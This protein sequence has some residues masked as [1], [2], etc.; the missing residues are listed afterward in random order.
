MKKLELYVVKDGKE[1]RCGYT[2]GSC[3]AA[4]TKA[5][6]LLLDGRLDSDAVVI[7][8]PKGIEIEIDVETAET[9]GDYAEVSVKKDSGDD[10][11]ITDGIEIFSKVRKREDGKISFTGG[12]GVGQITIDGFWGKAGE[13]AINP[14][15]RKMIENELRKISDSGYDVEISVPEGEEIG[16]KTFNP[17]IG[18]VGGISIIGTTG[19][20]DPMSEEAFKKCIFMEIDEAVSEGKK[21]IMLYPGNYGEKLAKEMY[22]DIPG[23]QIA[24]FVGESVLYC[25]LKEIEKIILIGHI[26]KFAKLS[27]GAFNTHSKVCD[28]RIEAFIYYLALRKD[29]EAID[30]IKKFR[31]SEEAVEYLKEKDK[32]DLIKDMKNGC[33]KRVRTYMRDEKFDLE[34]IIYSMKYGV[35][36]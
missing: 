8:T 9:D 15:P 2:T 32:L 23:V 11:D 21:E 30:D 31:T 14:A 5:A 36:S 33:E 18:I 13:P 6:A 25:Q 24:N 3:A 16:K 1:L 7:D 28:M 4:A 22:P 19:I 12:K 34:V 35:I 10:P 29:F 26:G 27:L 17:N 20:V